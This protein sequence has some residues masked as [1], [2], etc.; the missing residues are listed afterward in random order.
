MLRDEPYR[1]EIFE[2]EQQEKLLSE[3]LCEIYTLFKYISNG[4]NYHRNCLRNLKVLELGCGSGENL[5]LAISH[6]A[7]FVAGIDTTSSSIQSANSNF[8]KSQI[9]PSRFLFA[10]GNLFS[11]QSVEFSLPLNHYEGFF[12]RIMS[13]WVIS[14]AKNLNEVRELIGIAKRYLKANGDMIILVVN[15]MIIANFPAVRQLPRIENFRLVDVIE[16]G[17]HFKMKSQIL[18]PFSEDAIME[19]SH[20]VYSI[21]QIKSVLDEFGLSVKHCGNLELTPKDDHNS[22]PFEMISHELSK[23]TTMGY[24]IHVKKPKNIE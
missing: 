1:I 13:C 11:S 22:Y 14:Q 24:F 5:S 20:N 9:D 10:K 6:G 16:E 7:S 2:N 12:D 21:E 18:Q 19:V 23:D 17:D 8:A 4:L 3:D 15:P